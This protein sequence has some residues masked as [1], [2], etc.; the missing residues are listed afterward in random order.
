MTNGGLARESV[1]RALGAKTYRAA[2]S[3]LGFPRPLLTLPEIQR[4]NAHLAAMVERRPSVRIGLLRTYTTEL[5]KPYWLLEA[6]LAGFRLDPY[7]APLGS[8]L[9]E[10]RAESG[11]RAHQPEATFLFLKWSDLDARLLAPASLEG[12]REREGVFAA[13]EKRLLDLVAPLREALPGLLVVT[14]LPPGALP[15][16]EASG[17]PP[18]EPGRDRTW[19]ERVAEALRKIPA[20]HF[21]DLESVL[22][23]TAP[24]GPFDHRLWRVA[25]FPF[26]VTG[27]QRVVRALFVPVWLLR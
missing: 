4:L 2:R 9:Q 16:G 5:L 27:A 18:L 8:L 6:S 11:L 22:A 3:A 24:D 25:S 14:L 17:P 26:S 12:P 15:E 1:K 20:V 19:P 7:E 23:G 13:A 21:V 10:G